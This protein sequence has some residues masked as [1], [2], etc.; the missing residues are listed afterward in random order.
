MK[1]HC[2]YVSF[3]PVSI[4]SEIILAKVSCCIQKKKESAIHFHLR[5]IGAF[6]CRVPISVM[7]LAISFL[8]CTIQL[9]E[10]THRALPKIFT[11]PHTDFKVN[12]YAAGGRGRI[13]Q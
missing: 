8:G 9:V 2:L 6:L 10:P 4:A 7:E 5:G 12:R 1:R 11:E 3:Y 13:C